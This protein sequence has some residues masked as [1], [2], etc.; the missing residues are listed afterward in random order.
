MWKRIP[1]LPIICYLNRCQLLCLLN[2]DWQV[3]CTVPVHIF[4]LCAFTWGYLFPTICPS[5][6]LILPPPT[7]LDSCTFWK[8]F[9]QWN[10]MVC[11]EPSSVQCWMESSL[12][13]YVIAISSWS[14]LFLEFFWTYQ[15]RKAC[16]W[17]LWCVF[18]SCM[19]TRRHLTQG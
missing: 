12:I 8:P 7:Q 18:L 5:E 2:C 16:D 14:V 17:L 6:T 10:L 19:Y 13:L 9:W 15:K 1:S 4:V 11:N 3:V